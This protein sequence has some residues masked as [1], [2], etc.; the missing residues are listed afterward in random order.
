MLTT[1]AKGQAK[2]WTAGYGKGVSAPVFTLSMEVFLNL[3]RAVNFVP[4]V[5]CC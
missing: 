5:F 1:Q 4:A 2:L 3:Y